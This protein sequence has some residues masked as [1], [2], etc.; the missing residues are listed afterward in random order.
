MYF[1][2]SA[3]SRASRNFW[4]GKLRPDGRSVSLANN[5]CSDSRSF[6]SFFARATLIVHGDCSKR[7]GARLFL[8]HPR[9]EGWPVGLARGLR[10]EV[11][12]AAMIPN[13][14]PMILGTVLTGAAY[15]ALIAFTF[16]MWRTVRAGKSRLPGLPWVVAHWVLIHPWL[17]EGN[18]RQISSLD[19]GGRKEIVRTLAQAVDS[20]LL[21]Q[22]GAF[23]A[24]WSLSSLFWA[25]GALGTA[26]LLISDAA[27][28]LSS[29]GV[30]LPAPLRA[31]V[32][33]RILVPFVGVATV[34]G[35]LLYHLLAVVLRSP[36]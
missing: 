12:M 26:L 18:I 28:L 8:F 34:L 31:L 11:I 29:H 33:M 4:A 27:L 15:F 13:T 7:L 9:G 2:I 14:W 32:A 1:P 36:S 25:L 19:T 5:R 21:S 6:S 3:P 35:S 30:A 22:P 20:S 17:L 16:W 24:L 23:S 10:A